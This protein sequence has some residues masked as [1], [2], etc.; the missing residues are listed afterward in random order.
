MLQCVAVCCSKLQC[1]A[2]CRSVSQCVAVC[3]SVLQRP[4]WGVYSKRGRQVCIASTCLLV[5]FR[6]AS[7]YVWFCTRKDW[8]TKKGKFVFH[9]PHNRPFLYQAVQG[10]SKNESF[11]RTGLGTCKNELSLR[12]SPRNP[13][14]TQNEILHVP[15]TVLEKVHFCMF[16]N[17]ILEKVSCFD[18]P[19]RLGRKGANLW[20]ISNTNLPFLVK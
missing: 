17:T 5:N 9:I 6:E 14:N 8:L 4:D 15:R 3:R 7:L 10:V 16:L 20:G 2:V 19:A 18:A 1:V 11:S 12:K 13:R